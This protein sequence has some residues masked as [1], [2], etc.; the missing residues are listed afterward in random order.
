M[1]AFEIMHKYLDSLPQQGLE[2][3]IT[4][5]ETAGYADLSEANIITRRGV[6]TE[7]AYPLA[8]PTCALT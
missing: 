5:C 2:P 7:Y 3:I 8:S 1:P 6:L 4:S